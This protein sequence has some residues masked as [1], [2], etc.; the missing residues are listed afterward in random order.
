MGPGASRMRSSARHQSSELE[1]FLDSQDK[2]ISLEAATTLRGSL[3][4]L[5]LRYI[6]IAESML[7]TIPRRTRLFPHYHTTFTS[8]EGWCVSTRKLG[9]PASVVLCD[10]M[11]NL[12]CFGLE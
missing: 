1:R 10:T 5:G 2:R 8:R 4:T 9:L 3:T 12:R 6:L 7:G 11:E